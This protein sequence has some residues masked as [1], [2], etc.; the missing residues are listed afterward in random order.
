MLNTQQPDLHQDQKKK[1]NQNHFL[2]KHTGCFKGFHR[3]LL[4]L[5]VAKPETILFLLP[6]PYVTK[7]IFLADSPSDNHPPGSPRFEGHHSVLS[8]DRKKS[9]PV[10]EAVLRSAQR[11]HKLLRQVVPVKFLCRFL[12][13]TV[14]ES[15]KRPDYYRIPAGSGSVLLP[16]IPYLPVRKVS[17]SSFFSDKTL[18]SGFPQKSVIFPVIRTLFQLFTYPAIC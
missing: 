7:D 13:N 9:R 5:T 18:R 11:N 12:Y 16:L 10:S 8:A 15:H 2:D 14:P 1:R 4:S 17:D 3:C 6:V